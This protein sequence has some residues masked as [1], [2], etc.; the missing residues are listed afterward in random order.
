MRCFSPVVALILALAHPVQA[1]PTAD[2][3]GLRAIRDQAQALDATARTTPPPSWLGLAPETAG[4]AAGDDLGREALSR[5]QEAPPAV[6]A[7]KD[8]G[9]LCGT[10]QAAAEPMA[11]PAEPPGVTYTV[12]VSRSLGTEALRAIFRAASG[13]DV[14]FLFRG[15]APGERLMDMIKAIHA[16]L[17]GIDPVPAV[18]IDPTV[19]REAGATVVPLLIARG[20]DGEL[21]RVTGLTAPAWLREQLQGGARGDLGVRGPAVAISEVDLIEEL[22]R[23]VAAL[24]MDTLR[25]GAIKRYWQ[26]A[27]FDTLPVVT[28]P[29]ERTIDPTVT[30]SADVLLP[31]GTKVIQAGASVNPLD[32][33]PFTHRLIVFDASDPRQVETA[34]RLGETD[35]PQRPLYLATR[36]DR[37]QG[38]DGLRAVE[39]RLDEPVYLLTPDVRTRF[40]LERVPALVEARGR[41]FV[42]HEVL[43]DGLP[44]G[45]PMESKQ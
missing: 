17:D 28:E 31:D 43:P 5:M 8:L 19:F 26:R 21:A 40:A 30:A 37:D 36:F 35:S 39:D 44:M 34:R 32:H 24:D 18:E 41:V 11:R 2:P 3:L 6:S 29:R 45:Q 38:W 22:Q 27:T 25:E 15:V 4:A 20:P 13:R 42:V 16:L 14:R 23:R 12:L 1:A 33:V 7:C 9:Q 10:G